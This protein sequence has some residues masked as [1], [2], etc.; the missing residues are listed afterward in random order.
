MPIRSLCITG[1]ADRPTLETFIGMHRQGI[2]LTVV[3]PAQHPHSALLEEAGIPTL[4]LTLDRMYD[5]AGIAALREA[6]VRDRHHVVHTFNNRAVTNGLAACKGMDVRIVCYRGVVGNVSVLDPVSW[7]RY[8]NPRIDRIV[9]VC[10][11]V[12]RYFLELWPA[13][14]RLPASRLVTIYKGHEL[15]WYD[16]PPVGRDS[17]G[18]SKGAF[19]I[20]CAAAYRPRKGI[21]Y[22]VEALERLPRD[23]PAEL[24]LIGNMDAGRLTRRIGDSPVKDRVR[25]IGFRRDAPAVSGA[26][27]VFCLPSTAREGLPR[28]VIEAMAY[29]V[30]PVVTDSGGSPELVVDGESGIVVPA[31]DAQALANAFEAL[32]RDQERRL[33]MGS[34]ARTRIATHF[35]NTET[36]RQTIA[37]YEELVPDP[38]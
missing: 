15:E 36:V 6:L 11:A 22:L 19:V 25:R 34:A 5:R 2:A 23:I 27:D 24:L 12:R 8:L 26:C 4:D 35:R 30:P 13:A 33:R 20:G 31:R 21:E 7:L 32:Y 9:C 3:C 16:D 37:L 1:G 17:L 14:L 10:E 18:V 29:G 28:A 38:D